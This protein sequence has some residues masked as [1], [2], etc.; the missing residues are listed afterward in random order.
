MAGLAGIIYPE[1]F[2]VGQ[3][4]SPMLGAMRQRG[5]D[6]THTFIYRELQLG[7]RGTAPGSSGRHKTVVLFDGQL[8]KRACLCQDLKR[9]GL[10]LDGAEDAELLAHAYDQWGISCLQR[11]EGSFAMAIFD[12]RNELLY[13]VRDPLG[14]SPLYWYQ[15]SH[16]FLFA[17]DMKA[18]MASGI[19]PHRPDQAGLGVYCFLG[20][21]PQD[22]TLVQDVSRLLPGHY[23]RAT[24]GGSISVNR[25]WNPPP[26]WTQEEHKSVSS[27]SHSWKDVLKHSVDLSLSELDLSTGQI[28]CVSGDGPGEA[29]LTECLKQSL[30]ANV[31]SY[32]ICFQGVSEPSIE[33]TKAHRLMVSTDSLLDE[34]VS[35][36]WYLGEP[37]ADIYAIANWKLVR[38]CR[39]DGITHLYS[40]TGVDNILRSAQQNMGPRRPSG[41]TSCLKSVFRLGKQGLLRI[42][43]TLYPLWALKLKQSIYRD[44]TT[45]ESLTRYDQGYEWA[46]PQILATLAPDL[47]RLVNEG[48]IIQRFFSPTSISSLTNTH[49]NS[50]FYGQLPDSELLHWERASSTRGI[51]WPTPFLTNAALPHLPHILREL[52]GKSK[53]VHPFTYP[54]ARDSGIHRVFHLLSKGSLVGAGLINPKAVQ[55]ML[56]AATHDPSL[57]QPLWNLLMLE[58]WYRLFI[59]NLLPL[60]PP[61]IGVEDYLQS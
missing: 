47:T 2:E 29:I 39:A 16:H 15:G 12:Q 36:V 7:C 45:E 54:W 51:R 42:L 20:W 26:S 58:L 11:I 19:V 8:S 6:P 60:E 31:H 24:L 3:L 57:T 28:A 56:K 27:L 22:L 35:L 1:L 61:D 32:H 38:R 23:L 18:L 21:T 49:F 33:S 52:K 40:A 10:L 5:V 43:D 53:A 17:S 48:L 25:Y 46:A 41:L 59:H 4:V 9:E 34:L 30:G 37:L 13:L 55:Q 44:K 14:K 50:V